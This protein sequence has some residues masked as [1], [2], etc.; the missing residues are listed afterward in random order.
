VAAVMMSRSAGTSRVSAH[1]I[2][3]ADDKEHYECAQHD[4]DDHRVLACVF[5]FRLEHVDSFPAERAFETR[6]GSVRLYDKRSRGIAPSFSE[7]SPSTAPFPARVTAPNANVAAA[8]SMSEPLSGFRIPCGALSSE[9]SGTGNRRI[10]KLRT[11]LA[12]SAGEV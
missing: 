5:R 4:N 3:V 11:S 7:S 9:V 12:G 2:E 10:T 8:L 1:E 6:L